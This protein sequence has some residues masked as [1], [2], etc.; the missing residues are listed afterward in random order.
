MRAVRVA[1]EVVKIL[2]K[3]ITCTGK[4]MKPPFIEKV[5]TVTLNR[6]FSILQLIQFNKEETAMLEKESCSGR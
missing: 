5:S 3:C 6:I 1:I 4:L 2:R